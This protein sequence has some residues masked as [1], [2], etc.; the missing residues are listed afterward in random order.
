MNVQESSTSNI[1]EILDIADSQMPDNAVVSKIPVFYRTL[2]NSSALIN[3][4][5]WVPMK[6]DT[7]SLKESIQRHKKD[8]ELF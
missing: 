2:F 7:Q 5:F 8:L 1:Q 6:Q 3:E 4:D